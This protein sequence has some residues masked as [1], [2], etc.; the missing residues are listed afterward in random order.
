MF[1]LYS[2]Y[3]R[4]NLGD[5]QHLYWDY[6]VLTAYSRKVLDYS[7][8]AYWP[9]NELSGS[10]AYDLSGNEFNG[11]YTGVTLG[12]TGI[13]DGDPCPLF[14]GANDFVNIY[15]AGLNAA[16]DQSECTIMLWF[17]VSGVGVWADGA[18]RYLLRLYVDNDNTFQAVKATGDNTITS[19]IEGATVS[20][21]PGWTAGP[22]TGWKHFTVTISET[23]DRAI[24]YGNGSQVGATQTG[25][26]AWEGNLSATDTIIGALNT[27][28][29]QV[30]SGYLARMVIFPEEKTA[31]EIADLASV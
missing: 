14:D 8:I 22:G 18:T 11:T 24:L 16:W 1:P 13:G 19:K 10:V 27:G 15:S 31:T 29:L 9:L 20:K 12:Q 4:P 21:Y 2:S 5:D 28:A 25:L 30:W 3:L 23:N 7:P 6:N 26:G 17:R